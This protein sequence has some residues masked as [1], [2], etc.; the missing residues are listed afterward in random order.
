MVYVP[1][2]STEY[3]ISSLL[4]SLIFSKSS[5][6]SWERDE[7]S[8]LESRENDR[9]EAQITPGLLDALKER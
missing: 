8:T 2:T 6:Q 7:K 9:Y 1:L 5:S 4:L 3:E